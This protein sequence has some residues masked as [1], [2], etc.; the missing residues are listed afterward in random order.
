MLSDQRN[1]RIKIIAKDD[2][3]Q[4]KT[5]MDSENNEAGQDAVNA[6][7][8]GQ[9]LDYQFGVNPKYIA[10]AISNIFSEDISIKFSGGKNPCCI[11]PIGSSNSKAI[12]MPVRI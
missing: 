8:K 11:S 5:V 6:E 12:I 1:P 2:Y 7:F 4:L 9:P 10:D 3:I